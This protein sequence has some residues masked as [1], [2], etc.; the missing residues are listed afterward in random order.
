ML[1]IPFLLVVNFIYAQTHPLFKITQ[2]DKIGYINNRGQTVIKPV[3][4]NGSDFS[5]GLAAVR[6]DGMYG[7]IDQTGRFVLP[8]QYDYAQPFSRGTAIVYQDGRP[9]LINKTG[10][11]SIPGAYGELVYIDDSKAI[12]T[13]TTAKRGIIDLHTK[14]LLVD[15]V[16]ETIDTF[17]GDIAIVKMPFS[18]KTDDRYPKTGVVDYT[19]KM[20][21][22][23]GKYDEIR[24]FT[25]GIAV[26]HKH[27]K[28]DKARGADAVIDVNGNVLFSK[29][30]DYTTHID[31]S[32]H[33]GIGRI[34]SPKIKQEANATTY[35]KGEY[36]YINLEGEVVFRDGPDC[37]ALTPFANGRT[38]ASNRRNHYILLDR[39]F[40]RVGQEEFTGL[41]EGGFMN[42]LAIVRNKNGHGIIDTTGRFVV[43]ANYE[44]IYAITGNHFFFSETQ[45]AHEV[46]ED[47]VLYGF[48]DLKGH[49]IMKPQMDH[50]DRRGFRDGLLMAGINGKLTYVNKQGE[51]VWQE[52]ERKT[53][54]LKPL[55]IDYMNR[56]YFKAYS[57]PERGDEDYRAHNIPKQITT[58]GLPDN[59]L[60]VTIDTTR[61]DTFQQQFAGMPLFISNTTR[62]TVRFNAQ[63]H[64]LYMTLQALD[65]KG[66]WRDI[67][68]LPNS[69]CG[70]SYHQV[71]LEPN[72]GWGFII[73]AYQGENTT[74]MRAKLLYIDKDHPKKS[75]VVYSNEIRAGVNPAQFWNK[76]A[77]YPDGIMNPYVD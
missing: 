45:D 15:T 40:K 39:S 58:P 74:L 38:F 69:W 16:F 20:V 37:K 47:K 57:T 55:N 21:V 41:G 52:S 36:S 4:L 26:T 68:Y 11:I 49:V 61:I 60:A 9:S 67:E 51:I 24:P 19:G 25:D 76:A 18:I 43:A 50:F 23:L 56:G 29:P 27:A 44:D 48:G 6:K 72:A 75:K 70:N 22:P 64:L 14:Q 10:Q 66:Q 54:G 2:Y 1:T 8:P 53:H 62:D 13:T 30:S 35:S 32:F 31:G 17:D 63:D 77:Y 71:E 5:E 28:G 3:F 73:P 59:K 42:G 33:E 7:F 12:V 65:T 46:D 34:S